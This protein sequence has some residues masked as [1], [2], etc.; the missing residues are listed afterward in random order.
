MTRGGP[1]AT[2]AARVGDHRPSAPISAAPS[3][4]DPSSQVDHHAA[5]ALLEADQPFGSLE[6]DLVALAAR[7]QDGA[8]QVAAVH[9][10]VRVLE[11]CA[12]GIAERDA[13]ELLAGDRIGHDERVRIDHVRLHRL[14]Y[15]QPFEQRVDVRPHL[16]AVADLAE[17]G[18]LLEDA[19]RAGP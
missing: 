4:C 13:R 5:V 6:R 19:A 12:E 11:A 15:A 10:E 3:Y 7:G 2:T 17:L 8:V 9:D 18:G 16:D 14:E 1:S